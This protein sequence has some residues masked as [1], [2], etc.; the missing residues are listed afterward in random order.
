MDA[1]FKLYEF[2]Y[3][4]TQGLS[5]SELLNQVAQFLANEA[6]QQG[7]ARG[8]IFE[9]C[10]DVRQISPGEHHYKFQVLGRYIDPENTDSFEN[11]AATQVPVLPLERP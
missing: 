8:Y 11:E 2:E 9:Q 4:D 5:E 7:W 3:I 6:E 1:T 10:Q